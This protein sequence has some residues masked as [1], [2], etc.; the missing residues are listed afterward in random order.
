MSDGVKAKENS[1]QLG[2]DGTDS[3]YIVIDGVVF[4]PV[5]FDDECGF[6]INDLENGLQERIHEATKKAAEALSLEVL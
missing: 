3:S 2:N 1:I 4:A 5:G 6:D